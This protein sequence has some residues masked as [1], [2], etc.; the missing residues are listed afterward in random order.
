[1]DHDQDSLL[2]VPQHPRI[3]PISFL[4]IPIT[5][6]HPCQHWWLCWSVWQPQIFPSSNFGSNP[7]LFLLFSL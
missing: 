6:Y 4:Y 3:I 7:L 1:M 2:Y 5:I